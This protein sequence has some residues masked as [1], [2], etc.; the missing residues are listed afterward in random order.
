MGCGK[1]A[2]ILY[3]KSVRI[4]LGRGDKGPGKP[5]KKPSAFSPKGFFLV[6]PRRSLM[7]ERVEIPVA[8]QRSRRP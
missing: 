8:D 5:G 1:C 2:R 4:E 7:A 3:P 6:R